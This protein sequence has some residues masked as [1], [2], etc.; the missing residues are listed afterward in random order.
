MK[1]YFANSIHTH[2]PKLVNELGVFTVDDAQ[3]KIDGIAPGEA[4][5]AQAALNRAKV[6]FSAI[7]N[8]PNGFNTNNLTHLLEFNSGENLRFYL[9]RNSRYF[10]RTSWLYSSCNSWARC[11][12]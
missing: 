12:Y 4:G 1:K 7:A 9:V 3:G 2:A 11:R 10:R 6:I 5:Y 8:L